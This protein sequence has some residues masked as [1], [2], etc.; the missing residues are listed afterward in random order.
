M[1]LKLKTKN[2]KNE[3]E[4]FINQFIDN[5]KTR[6][7]VKAIILLGGLGKRSFID[8]FSD[9]DMSIVTTDSDRSNFPL[10]FEFHTKFNNR[11]IEFNI[12][13]LILE[14][15]IKD[16]NH[17]GEGKIEAY[18]NAIIAYDPFGYA[19]Q[20]LK[21]KA[22]FDEKKAY[23]RMI[24]IMQQYKWRGQIHSIRCYKRGCPEASH[25]LL[26]HCVELLLEAVF[27]LNGRYMPHRKWIFIFLDELKFGK[28]LKE[29]FSKAMIVQNYS[30]E[31]ILERITI[32][33]A[34]HK[35]IQ[36]E[37]NKKYKNFP[38]NPYVYYYRNK[39]QVNKITQ[40][41]KVYKKLTGKEGIDNQKDK[42]LFGEICFNVDKL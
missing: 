17:W 7:E 27:L 37:V 32:L 29:L 30:Y 14:E 4:V 34:I 16:D 33:D 22:V 25:D 23:D 42:E 2:I 18:S 5:L 35:E 3:I 21:E 11:F 8:E 1:I 28:S 15:E 31:S 13:Q 40:A 6:K 26:N 39:V 12:H 19:N 20:I 24:W 10:P 9:V 41:D 38:Q 36:K